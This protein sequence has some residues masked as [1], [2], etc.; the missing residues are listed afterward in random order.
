MTE[1]LR[2]PNGFYLLRAEE[3]TYRPL[4]QVR[5]QIFSELKQQEYAKWMDNMTKT[6][7]VQFTSP[8]FLGLKR[9]APAAPGR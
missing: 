7:N 8:E 2:Q 1:P 4:S 5:D 6:N 9:P 3:V